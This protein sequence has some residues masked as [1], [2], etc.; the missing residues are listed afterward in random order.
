M[1]WNGGSSTP[2]FEGGSSAQERSFYMETWRRAIPRSRAE[3]AVGLRSRYGSCCHICPQA[4]HTNHRITA[5]WIPSTNVDLH[6]GHCGLDAARRR[7]I[8]NFSSDF[9][10]LRS[11]MQQV[12]ARTVSLG[13]PV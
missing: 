1:N 10:C 8:P 6:F 7:S 2:V 11:E 9:P 3:L 5:S 4:R 13:V 12:P